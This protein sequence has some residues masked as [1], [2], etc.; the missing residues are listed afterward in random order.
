MPFYPNCPFPGRAESYGSCHTHSNACYFLT[1]GRSNIPRADK[2][3]PFYPD[4]VKLSSNSVASKMTN[5]L[6][7]ISASG[8]VPELTPNMTARGIR[9]GA[10]D[11]MALNRFCVLAAIA[12]RGGWDL[13][14]IVWPLD[15]L[16]GSCSSLSPESP[17]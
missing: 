4:L 1:A 7:D 11:T 13:K 16:P 17:L 9:I 15:I 6:H 3:Q 12:S 14:A 10:A 8:E 5:L 2:R